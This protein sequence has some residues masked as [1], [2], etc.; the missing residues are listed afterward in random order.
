VRPPF[1]LQA[2][3]VSLGLVPDIGGSVSQLRAGT[4]DLMRPL[5][6][7]HWASGDVLGTAMFPMVPYANRI[8][9][10]R[11]HFG[12]AAWEVE[13]NNPPERFNV[14]GTGWRVPWTVDR[15][16]RDEALLSLDHAALPDP[17]CLSGR[18]A[19]RVD[20]RVPFRDDD[21]HQ[22]REVLDAVWLWPALLV[23]SERRCESGVLGRT[24]LA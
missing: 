23:R 7:A 12:G 14:H 18:A 24:L 4:T 8:E 15:L 5:S 13:T 1:E 17:L 21:A 10:N 3:Q 16:L 19:F 22:S 9:G 20:A 6:A 2:G 11:L